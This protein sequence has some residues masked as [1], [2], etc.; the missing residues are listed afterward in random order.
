MPDRSDE[1]DYL[2]EALKIVGGTTTLLPESAHLV[3]LE[4]QLQAMNK[5]IVV[6]G[7]LLLAVLS[8]NN[9]KGMEIPQRVL[10]QVRRSQTMPL[11][12]QQPNGAIV[13]KVVPIGGP[14]VAKQPARVM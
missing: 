8:D 11:I 4:S 12:H 13:V 3:A 7:E 5:N 10:E 6:L 2:Q 14:A 9:V 1:R